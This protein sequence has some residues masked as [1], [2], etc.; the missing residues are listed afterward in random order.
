MND[1]LGG[2]LS[3]P[4][5]TLVVVFLVVVIGGRLRGLSLRVGIREV[6]VVLVCYAAAGLVLSWSEEDAA[7]LLLLAIALGGVAVVS[8]ALVVR[9]RTRG[10]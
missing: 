9:R 10:H 6:L 5:P 4:I 2:L 3:V 7:R 1:M 8:L